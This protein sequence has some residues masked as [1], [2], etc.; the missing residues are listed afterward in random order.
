MGVINRLLLLANTKSDFIDKIRRAKEKN[1]PTEFTKT[2]FVSI[3]DS[4][5]NWSTYNGF[6]LQGKDNPSGTIIS[7]SLVNGVGLFKSN[8]QG[9]NYNLTKQLKSADAPTGWWHPNYDSGIRPV[10]NASSHYG[11]DFLWVETATEGRLTVYK[12][13][14]TCNIPKFNKPD[15]IDYEDL[16]ITY[17]QS[18][19]ESDLMAIDSYLRSHALNYSD[20]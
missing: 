14:F 15:N 12:I 13:N 2:R 5:V 9:L 19:L 16:V 6:T 17:W 4:F 10:Y 7:G 8:I 3:G 11:G 18:G 1:D 20:L